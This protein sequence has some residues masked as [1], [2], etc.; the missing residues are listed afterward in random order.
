MGAIALTPGTAMA[1]DGSDY[2]DRLHLSGASSG[3]DDD[4][5]YESSPVVVGG[6]AGSNDRALCR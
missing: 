4:A 2:E 3:S 5:D 1:T 6:H